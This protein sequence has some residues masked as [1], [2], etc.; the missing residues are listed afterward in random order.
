M[1]KRVD[2]IAR[3]WDL[4]LTHLVLLLLLDGGDDAPRRT[5]SS[6]HVFVGHRQEVPLLHG[7]LHVQG[8]HLLHRLD[9]FCGGKDRQG[10]D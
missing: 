10:K 1:R 4:C 3:D 6:D 5:T 7:Q 9:H 2:L 8:G